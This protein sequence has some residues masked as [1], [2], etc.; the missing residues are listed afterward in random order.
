MTALK[1]AMV[2]IETGIRK[3]DDRQKKTGGSESASCR[4]YCKEDIRTGA[5][6]FWI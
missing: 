5:F 6:S 4:Q 2:D 1:K 3:A